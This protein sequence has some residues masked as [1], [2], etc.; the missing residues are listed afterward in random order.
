MRHHLCPGCIGIRK[1]IHSLIDVVTEKMGLD[2]RNG[3]VFIFIVSRC[4]L[5]KLQYIEDGRMVMYVKRLEA[6]LFRIPEYDKAT[7]TIS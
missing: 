4:R 2:V 3:D 6:V 7:K 5:M 1:G